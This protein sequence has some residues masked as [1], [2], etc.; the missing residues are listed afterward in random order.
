MNLF[1]YH[2]LARSEPIPL[3]LKCF[4]LSPNSSS[5]TNPNSSLLPG[6]ERSWEGRIGQHV[7]G[8]HERANPEN[9]NEYGDD[10]GVPL[11]SIH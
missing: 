6:G 10:V 11:A 5:L 1:F 3:L 9:T 8:Q 4:S 2:Y 7:V